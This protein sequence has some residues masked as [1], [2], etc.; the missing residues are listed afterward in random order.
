MVDP[1]GCRQC[2]PPLRVQI[3][4]FWHTKFSKHSC[5]G[6]WHPPYKVGAPLWEIL[7]PLPPP[8]PGGSSSTTTSGGS[9]STTTSGGSSFT[10]TSGWVLFHY[11]FWGVPCDLSH[12]ALIYCYRIP[13]CIMGKIHMGPPPSWTDWLTDKYNW[14]HYIPAHYMVRAVTIDILVFSKWVWQIRQICQILLKCL[15][16]T[17]STSSWALNVLNANL[18]HSRMN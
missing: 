18:R 17:P 7:D 15:V 9:S 10:T 5:L 4:S 11:H 6:S 13:Q 3:L 14:K 2:V 12:N 16:F 1:G 8:L